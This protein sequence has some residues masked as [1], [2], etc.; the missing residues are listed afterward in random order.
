MVGYY[1]YNTPRIYEAVKEAGKLGKITIVGFDEDPIT[2]GGVK[3]G[4][5]AA[6]VVQQPYEWGYQGMKLMAKYFEGRQVR[7]SGQ[8]SHHHPDQDH[9]Q[10][11][12]RCLLGGSEGAA[13]QEIEPLTSGREAPLALLPVHGRRAYGAAP[14]FVLRTEFASS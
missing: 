7:H 9:R 11:Q 5:I 14:S 2:L 3:E 8:P 6:T 1:S 10:G 12:C 13:G 4:T